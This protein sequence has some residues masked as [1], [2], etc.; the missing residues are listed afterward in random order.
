[1]IACL[2]LIHDLCLLFLM[3]LDSFKHLKLFKYYNLPFDLKYSV[4]ILESLVSIKKI[5]LKFEEFGH[6][7]SQCK[8]STHVNIF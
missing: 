6:F 4:R 7:A 3:C 2:R 5:Q 1:M 8:I